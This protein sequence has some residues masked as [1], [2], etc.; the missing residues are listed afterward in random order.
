MYCYTFVNEFSCIFNE[1]QLWSHISSD[2][3]NFLKIVASLSNVK[4]PKEAVA[5]LDDLHKTFH[6]LYTYVKRLKKHILGNPDLNDKDIR[7]VKKTIHDF[8]LYDSQALCFYP[9]L[10]EFGE[11]NKAWQELV[12][13]IIDE[14]LFMLDLFKDL[15]Q[16]IKRIDL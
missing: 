7:A 4:L 13:H 12:K 10:L 9:E 15:R 14:Q 5:T 11:E 3:P 1:L 16:Q 8:L 2:H 6:G